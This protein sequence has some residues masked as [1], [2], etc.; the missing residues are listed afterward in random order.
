MAVYGI[1][2]MAGIFTD[3]RG[4]AETSLT[5]LCRVTIAITRE[6]EYRRA[7]SFARL[8]SALRYNAG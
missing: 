5:L 1:A 6:A 3:S 4:N 8:A 2:R 7:A